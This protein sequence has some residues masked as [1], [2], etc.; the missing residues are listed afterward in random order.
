MRF[1]GRERR[2]IGRLRQLRPELTELLD[3]L[4]SVAELAERSVGIAPPIDDLRPLAGFPPLFPSEFPLDERRAV[5]MFRELLDAF[6]QTVGSDVAERART[7]LDA[8]ELDVRALICAYC[9]ADAR[10]FQAVGRRIEGLE[11]EFLVVLAELAVKPQFIAAARA[12]EGDVR[13]PEAHEREDRCPYCGSPPEIALITDRKAAERI[14]IA[15][16]RLCESEWPI[17]RVRCLS[18]G[19]EDAEALS[20]LQVEGEE[21]AR[22]DV[23]ESCR[24]YLPMLDTRGRLEVAPTVERAALAHLDL[25]AQGRGYQPL[26]PLLA[27]TAGRMAD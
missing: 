13:R 17:R 20:Y 27:Q 19:N 21:D 8:G 5:E 25:V 18:C 9:A 3:F 14:A 24:H 10:V 15:V 12:L 11:P 2:R 4:D 23:C 6:T 22:V 16:C 1:P 7:A 26:S